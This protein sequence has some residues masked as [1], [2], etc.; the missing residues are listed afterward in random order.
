MTDD[1]SFTDDDDDDDNYD[2]F[3]YA[4]TC[5]HSLFEDET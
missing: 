2:E 4:I 1:C 3:D 5:R